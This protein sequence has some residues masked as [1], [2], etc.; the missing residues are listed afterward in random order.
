[1]NGNLT[2]TVTSSALGPAAPPSPRSPDEHAAA[3]RDTTD[4][5]ASKSF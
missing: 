2:L 5:E 4:Q 1:M 3:L